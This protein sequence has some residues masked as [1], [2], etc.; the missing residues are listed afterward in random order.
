[1]TNDHRYRRL[2]EILSALLLLALFSAAVTFSQ[3][4]LQP[5]SPSRPVTP[6]EM[7]AFFFLLLGPIKILGPFVQM[8]RNTEL[9][10]ARELAVRA[11][12]VSCA[13]P[14]FAGSIGS[15]RCANITSPYLC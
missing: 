13:A 5:D 2:S 3:G 8:R 12:L 14:V 1:M 9:A 15:V 7:F 4:L 11:F 10:F 6:S